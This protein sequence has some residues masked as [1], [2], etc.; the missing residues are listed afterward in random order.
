MAV[1]NDFHPIVT[2]N[3][4][5]ALNHL[6]GLVVNF[7]VKFSNGDNRQIEVIIRPTNHL[8][9]R[10]VTDEDQS[11]KDALVS[12]GEWLVSFQHCETDFHRIKHTPPKIKEY[13]VFCEKKWKESHHLP[14]F[15]NLLSERP[16]QIT[17]L[18]N[19]GDDKTCLS[20]IL[21]LPEN[22]EL[23]FL[24][25]FK[26]HKLNPKQAS[27]LVE[28]AFCVP[29][30]HRKVERLSKR[31][32]QKPFIVVLKNIIE[33]RKPMIGI[34]RSNKQHKLRKKSKKQENL[35]VKRP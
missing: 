15:I 3:N 19:Q 17:V 4:R 6:K 26:L 11:N 18:A 29:I 31:D 33:G 12:S 5:Y 9:S 25:Y 34:R 22:P 2:S 20:G 10:E 24:V 27:M 13:R 7:D 8:F 23:A 32:E 28:T 21:P 14:D 30:S 1:N 16:N 35:K